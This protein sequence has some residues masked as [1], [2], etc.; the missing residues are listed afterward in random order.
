MK[1]RSKKPKPMPSEE[2]RTVKTITRQPLLFTYCKDKLPPIGVTVL[3]LLRD[4]RNHDWN[5]VCLGV[6]TG[7]KVFGKYEG[8]WRGSSR[9]NVFRD[10]GDD[11]GSHPIIAWCPVPVAVLPDQQIVTPTAAPVSA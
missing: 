1:T 3:V 5:D 10:G 6:R 2:A 8:D 4:A 9:W 7:M 11:F